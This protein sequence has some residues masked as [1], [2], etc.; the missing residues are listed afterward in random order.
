VLVYELDY[1]GGR[2]PSYF[3]KKAEVALR[4]FR[5][6]GFTD[7]SFKCGDTLGGRCGDTWPFI[8][9]DLCLLYPDPQRLVAYTDIT[10][11]LRNHA[12]RPAG[13]PADLE[14]EAYCALTQFSR[15]LLGAGTAHIPL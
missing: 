10:G 12:L 3:T 4:I 9:V 15:M 8:A 11:A 14:N 2:R 1:G 7:F 13:L 6:A 5:M